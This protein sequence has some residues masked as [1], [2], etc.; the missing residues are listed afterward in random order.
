MRRVSSAAFVRNFGLHSDTVLA[1]PI[2]VTRNGRARLVAVDR[3][4]YAGI[5][6]LALA[7]T[8]KSSLQARLRADLKVLSLSPP[9]R[10]K[11]PRAAP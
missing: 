11:T 5:L 3:D 1:S 6:N 4:S 10:A 8:S 2:L 7:E 9:R